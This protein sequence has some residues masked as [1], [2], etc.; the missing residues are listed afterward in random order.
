MIIYYKHPS[1]K[2]YLATYKNL[3]PEIV[4]QYENISHFA[5]CIEKIAIPDI[6]KNGDRTQYV[7]YED[8][9]DIIKLIASLKNPNEKYEIADI[10]MK[11]IPEEVPVYGH[12]KAVC[13]HCGAVNQQEEVSI[14]SLLFTFARDENWWAN[15][16]QLAAQAKKKKQKQTNG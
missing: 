8:P 7:E 11:I 16:R 12:H 6:R 1:L 13:P 4:T 10:V 9:N 3:L 14:S 15:S 2:S 5:F